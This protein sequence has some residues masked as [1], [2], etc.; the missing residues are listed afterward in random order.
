MK[1]REFVKVWGIVVIGKSMCCLLL[2]A[3]H[4][5]GGVRNAG[6]GRFCYGLAFDIIYKE[7]VCS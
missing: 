3:M 2:L 4:L 6:M 1:P 5:I 7:K